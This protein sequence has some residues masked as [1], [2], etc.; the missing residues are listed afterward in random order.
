MNPDSPRSIELKAKAGCRTISNTN[1]CAQNL[2]TKVS[3][4]NT[5][6]RRPC[7]AGCLDVLFGFF[8]SCGCLGCLTM[9]WRAGR[10]ACILFLFK[11]AVVI[12]S[13]TFP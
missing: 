4:S 10:L 13:T 1:I 5:L 6:F 12:D 11:F 8:R 2:P 7:C 9:Q 3:N